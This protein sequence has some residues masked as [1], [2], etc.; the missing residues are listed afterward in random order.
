[1]I[2]YRT[3]FP[4]LLAAMA[5][6]VLS[7]FAVVVMA[8]DKTP[9]PGD[10]YSP[11]VSEEQGFDGWYFMAAPENTDFLEY[12][13][14]YADGRWWAGENNFQMG[15]HADNQIHPGL[16]YDAVLAWE[17]P[18]SGS[19]TVS[20]PGGIGVNDSSSVERPGDG[21]T[22]GVFYQDDTGI[23]TLLG[24]TD[25]GNGEVREQDDITLDVR[26][27]ALILFRCGNGHDHYMDY[28]GTYLA[29]EITYN[30]VGG[31]DA[32]NK[33]L[34]PLQPGEKYPV[35]IGDPR[36]PDGTPWVL[37]DEAYEI[38]ASQSGSVIDVGKTFENTEI[39]ISASDVAVTNLT[40]WGGRVIVTGTRVTLVDST[41]DAPLE[42]TGAGFFAQ[43]CDLS[44]VTLSGTDAAAARCSIS[45]TV[46]LTGKNQT[47]YG[48]SISGGVTVSGASDV[49]VIANDFAMGAAAEITGAAY[50]N[51]SDNTQAGGALPDGFWRYDAR[52]ALWGSDLPGVMEASG[53][54]YVGADTSRLPQNDNTRFSDS[55]VRESIYY[56]GA[57]V[58]LSVYLSSVGAAYEEVILPA[59]IYENVP[60]LSILAQN[61]L[62]VAAYGVLA[63]FESYT[64]TALAIS[65][66]DG[67]AVRGLT[68]DHMRA[69]NA[70]GTVLSVSGNK[71]IWQPDQGYGFDITDTTLFAPEGAALA[72]RE[73]ETLPFADYSMT[74]RT[75][76]D[77]GTVTILQ[78]T[79][80][81]AGDRL[82]FR[83]RAAHVC[84]I[85]YAGTVTFADVTVWGG[86]G[87][88]FSG[89][90]GEGRI[91]MS[92]CLVVPGPKPE[93]AE[94][95]RMLS[96][97]DASHFSNMRIGPVMEDCVF[98]D[99]TDDGTNINGHYM[100]TS[101]YDAATRTFT[102]RD[103]FEVTTGTYSSQTSGVAVGDRIRV[104]TADYQFICDT[105]AQTT[106]DNGTLRIADA[107]DLPSEKMIL[108]NLDR[109][110]NDFVIRNCVVERIRSRGL[111]IKAGE[112][113]IAHCTLRDIR[114]SGILVKPES[115]QWP[116]FGFAENLVIRNNHII[117]TGYAAP[118]DN[119]HAAIN[120]SGDGGH[121][122]DPTFQLHRSIV[123]EGNLIENRRNEC[124]V[125]IAH[126]YDVT[127]KNNTFTARDIS[128][129]AK[130]DEDVQQP[131]T[132]ISATNVELTGN[133]WPASARGVAEIKTATTNIWG[134]DIGVENNP[135]ET[136]PPETE[137]A[138]AVTI[139]DSVSDALEIIGGADGPAAI[140]VAGSYMKIVVIVFAFIAVLCIVGGLIF[141]NRAQKK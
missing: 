5:V 19:V 60:P 66:S 117:G 52:E 109:Q 92:R 46:S 36:A 124:A 31:G 50:V 34:L 116:E 10:T 135:P 53:E 57:F 130:P 121:S 72:F 114:M 13:P 38:D 84:T 24:M 115:H 25:I 94:E 95:E 122:A 99:M 29:P 37:T 9:A 102:V 82:T 127:V 103:S 68:V 133:T 138:P 129:H 125:K 48:C 119:L 4:V 59:G 2:D 98:T 128:V 97:C 3:R 140:F 41:V 132:V 33:S 64:S 44:S 70:Q 49:S 80:L 56:N 11:Y 120:V 54:D 58:P 21:V 30:T 28:D 40:V 126:A 137:T 55:I 74:N 20:F 61:R 100:M 17:A 113:I 15:S 108:Q 35:S 78:A 89:W 27:G 105:V 26:A 123:I 104:L 23:R 87:F 42:V 76:N 69:A 91:T 43:H 96:T 12:L 63:R 14:F 81:G 18:A 47:L 6:L 107:P 85:N 86:S 88:A 131:V 16:N 90:E 101:S 32:L 65:Q 136:E 141:R 7:V 22:F 45:G 39:L 134:E 93:G 8:E 83:G 77:D 67:V 106:A 111:L 139:T 73:G 51:L 1:M 75:K 112:G 79:E 110:S 118:T 71:V 62:T